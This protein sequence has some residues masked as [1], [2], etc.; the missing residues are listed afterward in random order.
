MGVCV[1]CRESCFWK[2][3]LC[4][5]MWFASCGSLHQFLSMHCALRKRVTHMTHTQRTT[6]TTRSHDARPQRLLRK[7]THD[8][9]AHEHAHTTRTCTNMRTDA[10][11]HATMHTNTRTLTNTRSWADVNLKNW[12]IPNRKKKTQQS[13]HQ[14]HG[15]PKRGQQWNTTKR[16]Y[17]W[18]Y[19]DASRVYTFS[20]PMAYLFSCFAKE[21]V[22]AIAFCLWPFGRMTNRELV[23]FARTPLSHLKAKSFLWIKFM[24]EHA[25]TMFLA[26]ISGK[27]W[28]LAISKLTFVWYVFPWQICHTVAKICPRSCTLIAGH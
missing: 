26:I 11:T 3:S 6:R 13:A 10:R 23:T 8:T 24:A 1:L 25:C 21:M 5:C 22:F 20:R 7:R 18:K 4:V 16:R 28:K 9:H 14:E 19:C 27:H 15:K 17:Q 12:K 2:C